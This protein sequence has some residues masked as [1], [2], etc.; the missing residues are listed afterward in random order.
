M[1][2]FLVILVTALGLGGLYFLL[3]SGL[4]LIFGLM[5]VLN[6]AHGAFFG[7]GG[8]A[9]WI[10][11]D[12]LG[13]VDSLALR[14]LVS[15]V[16]AVAAGLLAG[17]VIE[18]VLVARSYGDHLAQIL[19]TLGLGFALNGLLAGLFTYSPR[20]LPQPEWLAATS[21]LG[22]AQIPNS[23][24]VI[25]VVAAVVFLG[26]IGFLRYTR[27]GLIIRAGAENRQMVRALGIDV[28]RSFTLVFALGG[29]LACLGGALGAVFFNGVTPTLGQNMLIFSFIV[30]IIGG[31]GSVPG[32][33]VAAVLV[34][35]VQQFTNFYANTGLGDLAI[36]VLLV[37]TLLVRP[38]GLLGRKAAST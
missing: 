8:Y 1:N 18:K 4:S 34:A 13:V 17:F 31:L 21:A 28:R 14:F 26:M 33:A 23:R 7:I 32:T 15:V 9:A 36:V 16:V 5:D 22:G 3:A 27:H 30:V 37:G 29:A 38:Q 10:V 24:L 35:L 11:M 25:I 19:L 20:S 12:S 6:L 2:A